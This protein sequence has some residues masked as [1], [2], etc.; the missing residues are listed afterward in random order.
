L[1][2]QLKIEYFLYKQTKDFYE[3]EHNKKT[4]NSR[5]RIRSSDA[6]NAE[7]CY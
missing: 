4:S 2:C 5:N 7:Q 1:I 3:I 6:S